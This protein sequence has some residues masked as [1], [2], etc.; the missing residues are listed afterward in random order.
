[1]VERINRLVKGTILMAIQSEKEVTKMVEDMVWAHRTTINKATGCSPF[2]MMR[3]RKPGSKLTPAWMLYGNPK[4]LEV[5]GEM[6]KKSD[7]VVGDWVKIKRGRLSGGLSKCMGPFKVRQACKEYVVL[8]NGN[9]WNRR[10]VAL[11]QKGNDRDVKLMHDVSD[12]NN[13]M[14]MSDE[15]LGCTSKG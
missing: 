13:F 12:G 8:E 10:R 3:G 15:E 5:K 7:V 11:Y 4:T 1:M 9:K 2:E 14:M 6:E